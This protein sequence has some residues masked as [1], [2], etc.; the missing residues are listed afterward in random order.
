MAVKKESPSFTKIKYLNLNGSKY[1]FSVPQNLSSSIDK[2]SGGSPSNEKR[3]T[4]NSEFLATHSK[5]I[6]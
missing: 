2:N 3:T 5:F 1:L 4:K 6:K